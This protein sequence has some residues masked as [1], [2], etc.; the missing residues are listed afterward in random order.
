MSSIVRAQQV[1]DKIK[2]ATGALPNSLEFES[3]VGGRCL[4]SGKSPGI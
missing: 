4:S 1:N 2:K 3:F